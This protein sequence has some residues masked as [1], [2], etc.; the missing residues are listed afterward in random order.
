MS[1]L[2]PE[3]TLAGRVD[4]IFKLD[5]LRIVPYEGVGEVLICRS[6]QTILNCQP[7]GR[8]TLNNSISTWGLRLSW[9]ECGSPPPRESAIARILL[10][11]FYS[12]N[13][14]RKWRLQHRHSGF[15]LCSQNDSS[16]VN[17]HIFCLC[18]KEFRDTVFR[19][20]TERRLAY[21]NI[22]FL[23]EGKSEFPGCITG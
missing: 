8:R 18:F 13:I 16:E 12:R 15:L 17:S 7:C 6:C 5:S 22:C 3:E 1:R 20:E 19:E 2:S 14:K 11:S 4:A 10:T 9:R 23:I 21:I